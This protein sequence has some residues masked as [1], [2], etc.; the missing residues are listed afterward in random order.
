MADCKLWRSIL[1]V[2]A[3]NDRFIESATRRPAD[4]LQID[5]EDSVAPPDKAEARGRVRDIARRFRAAGYDVT[6]RINRPWRLAVPDIEAAVCAD[7]AALTLPKVP[8]ASYIRS[9]A[10]ILDECEAEQGMEIGHSR[11][12]AMVEDAQGLS[13][14][15]AI[16]AAH[17]RVCGMIVG[18]EDLAA[19]M[20]MAVCE[21]SLYVPN[22]MAVTACRQ[23]GILPIGFVGSVADFND[24]DAFRATIRR[25]RRLGFDAAFCI[26][27]RQVDIVN[28]AFAPGSDEVQFATELLS[29]F[30]E[31]MRQG[32]AACTFR[33]RMVDLPV[34]QQARQLLAR[35]EALRQRDV[36]RRPPAPDKP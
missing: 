26:H 17:P 29:T 16:A 6:V 30:E 24:E 19:T 14:M 1:F 2:P 10:E 5:L 12:I 8:D 34:V 20:R 28:E 7:V 13:N 36:R 22:V 33:G 27:P 25:A 31:Q 32:K 18:A 15:N 3:S 9:I 4:V 21:D 35:H 11:L 23:A